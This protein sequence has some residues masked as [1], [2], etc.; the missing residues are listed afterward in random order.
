MDDQNDRSL[1]LLSVLVLLCVVLGY[2]SAAGAS[3]AGGFIL[4]L[5]ALGGDRDGDD[6]L[7]GVDGCPDEDASG[8]DADDDGCID[9]A[10]DLAQVV[11]ALELRQATERAL[12]ASAQS[13]ARETGTLAVNRLGAFINK[14]QAQRGKRLDDEHA[15]LLMSFAAH[16]SAVLQAVR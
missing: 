11:L 16:A 3:H 6:V 10:A 14:V 13:A 15:N 7:D 12:V 4:D 8:L 5:P 2:A 1:A 9:Q